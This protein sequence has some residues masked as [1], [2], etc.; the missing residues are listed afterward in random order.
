VVSAAERA[1][2][3]LQDHELFP[4]E[5]VSPSVNESEAL[6]SLMDALTAHAASAVAREREGCAKEVIRLAQNAGMEM[7]DHATLAGAICRDVIDAIRARG[8]GEALAAQ[9]GEVGGE[10]GRASGAS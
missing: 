10:G 9:E 4:S 2:A 1:R 8:G 5:G 6:H 7:S 3:W